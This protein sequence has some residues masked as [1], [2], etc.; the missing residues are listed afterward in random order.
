VTRNWSQTVSVADGTNWSDAA[1]A[2]RVYEYAVEPR[3][4]QDLPDYALLLVKGQGTGSVMQPVECDPAI[5]TL[6]R[7]TMDP[8]PPAVLPDH[9]VAAIPASGPP[10]HMV[11]SQ[12]APLGAP[13]PPPG[14]YATNTLPGWGSGAPQPQ[15]VY[16]PQQPQYPPQ[17]Y[18]PQQ[19]PPQ[20]YPP[21]P[22]YP[23]QYPPQQY[24]TER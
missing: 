10:T 3:A 24:P 14:T 18:P 17:Q 5:I 2:Q 22:P 12:P 7:V 6:P 9:S 15:P 13:A 21:Q 23:Q 8:L 11:I 16:P 4:L 1:S 19:Y 20:Q